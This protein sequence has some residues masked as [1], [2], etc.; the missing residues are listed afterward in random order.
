MAL[1]SL[2]IF[3]CIEP[4][5]ESPAPVPIADEV[6]AAAIDLAIDDAGRAWVSWVSDDRIFVAH[7]DGGPFTEGIS[8]V[9]SGYRP[10]VGTARRPH[11]AVDDERIAITFTDGV[12]PEAE[13][14]LFTGD[15]ISLD[16][17]G[18]LLGETGVNDTL[19]QPTV[20]FDDGE[21]WV[22]WKFGKDHEYGIALGTETD[23]YAPTVVSGFPGQPC[24]CCPHELTI[25][26][27]QPI[28]VQRGNELDL[29]EIYLGFLDEEG[30]AD[31]HR[32]SK[33]DWILA[34]CPYDGPET[35]RMADGRVLATWV[36]ATL[37]DARAWV[38]RSDDGGSS[39]DDATQVLPDSD[40]SQAYPRLTSNGED[41]WLSVEEI[42]STTHLFHSADGGVTFEEQMVAVDLVDVQLASG[43]GTTGMIGLDSD[44]HLVWSPLGSP[45]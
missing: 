44:D 26:E 16:F 1:F 41:I 9:G 24:E 45:R 18:R 2:L 29:R 21:I 33:N 25:V 30:V 42:W 38:S 19:D 13:V 34:G 31:V 37:G 6:E 32:V 7:S 14:W 23:D 3:A 43:G 35:T 10:S 8:V 5:P 36:D 11:L 22:A 27:G 12:T 17:E 20:A 28:L 15:K 4:P 40:R 39:W